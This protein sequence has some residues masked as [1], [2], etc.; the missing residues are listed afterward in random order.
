M[1]EVT[2]RR[3]LQAAVTAAGAALLSE[4]V[5]PVVAGD[6]SP[7]PVPSTLDG[8]A[9]ILKGVVVQ[10]A[11]FEDDPWTLMHGVRA[12]GREFTVKGER[13]VDLLC[14]RYLKQKTVGGKSYLYMPRE[15]EAHT[16]AFL[17]TILEAGVSPSH[18]FRLDGRRHT[19]GDLITGAKALFTFDPKKIDR[20]DLAWS[21]IAFSLQI[22]PTRE[23]WTN[24]L[25]QQIALS[26]VMRLGFDTLDQATR[27]FRKAKDQGVMPEAGDAILDFTCGGT[28]LLYGLASC[29]GN[30]HRREGFGKRLKDHLD[31]L[32]WRLDAD[33][34]LMDRFYRQR[35]VPPPGAPAEWERLS[36]L[37]YNDAKL[38]FYGHSFEILSYVKR[39]RLFT[40]TPAQARTIEGAG[41]TLAGAV[42]AIKGADLLE[43]RKTNLRLF[44]LLVGD[45]CH[46]YH[47]IHMAPGI[48]Q[49]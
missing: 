38:K 34:R 46:A 19:V 16:N 2:R 25:G 41:S 47:G 12:I 35:A 7:V 17:K 27:Q 3:F 24:G 14:S 5:P 11:R 48:N 42:K 43:I 22:P 21:L 44:H 40:P 29:V 10:Y 33:G 28:H 45:A 32:V 23:T 31:L 20:D 15:H 6:P 8:T 30:G 18:A 37:Y 26:D 36:A 49:V 4:A 1:V 39:Q 9:A 13:P